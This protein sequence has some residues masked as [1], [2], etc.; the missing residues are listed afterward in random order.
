MMNNDR[1]AVEEP[2]TRIALRCGSSS[3]LSTWLIGVALVG[4]V[5][6]VPTASADTVFNVTGTFANGASFE[7][8]ST[9][10]IDTV[11]GITTSSNLHI[12]AGSNPSP[13]NTF[14]E[15]DITEDGAFMTPFRWDLADGT[16]LVFFV[17][18]PPGF[19]GFSGG[20]ISLVTYVGPWGLSGGS[21][22][23]V[24]TPGPVP[25]PAA[26]CLLG[27]GAVGLMGLALWRKRLCS[28]AAC[29]SLVP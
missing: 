13:A 3:G 21:T 26:I 2:G 14:T 22:D 19:Q 24:L 1:R 7:S 6:M 11:N 29:G 12:S 20:T 5:I 23:T 17:P 10:T 8:G 16:D 18:E 9:V 27:I 28:V 15:A 4:L 25:E